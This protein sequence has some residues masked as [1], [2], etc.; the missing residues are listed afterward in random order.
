MFFLFK[1]KF[2]PYKI[3]A[4]IL[5][6]YF[7][8]YVLIASN[9]GLLFKNV[10]ELNLC[11]CNRLNFFLLFNIVLRVLNIGFVNITLSHGHSF[12]HFLE[13]FTNV[14]TL[15]ILLYSTQLMPIFISIGEKLAK[16]KESCNSRHKE[17]RWK[18]P[19]LFLNKDLWNV[20]RLRK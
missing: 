13:H 10:K 19:R 9:K 1:N 8:I 12:P 4:Y 11:N 2:F 6:L 7:H 17:L 20:F 18:N 16:I 15:S 3:F 14:I 5:F